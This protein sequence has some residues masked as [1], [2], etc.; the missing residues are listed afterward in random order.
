MKLQDTLLSMVYVFLKSWF[1][2][3]HSKNVVNKDFDNSLVE[4]TD[5]ANWN[6]V[7]IIN[8]N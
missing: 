2:P 8:K 4:Y 3:V 1:V 7:T 6:K 5:S